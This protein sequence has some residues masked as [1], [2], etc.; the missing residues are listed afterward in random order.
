LELA[1]LWERRSECPVAV[2]V[3]VC[4]NEI[5]VECDTGGAA[6]IQAWLEG[7]MIEGWRRS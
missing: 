6:D 3:I 2:P 1:L 5:V 7:A 4:H